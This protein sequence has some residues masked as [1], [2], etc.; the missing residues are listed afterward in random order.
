MNWQKGFVSVSQIQHMSD[1]VNTFNTCTFENT[2]NRRWTQSFKYGT[3]FWYNGMS[4]KF[5]NIAAARGI[6]QSRQCE[7]ILARK[8]VSDVNLGI[9]LALISGK[10]NFVKIYTSRSLCVRKEWCFSL[11]A[12]KIWPMHASA[13]FFWPMHLHRLHRPGSGPVYTWIICELYVEL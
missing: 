9:C 7:R 10:S 6:Y 3:H 2:Q 13:I 8:N 4:C 5:W 1:C 11:F 12:L